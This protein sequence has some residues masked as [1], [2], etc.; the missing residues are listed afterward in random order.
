VAGG[1]IFNPARMIHREVTA[2][3]DPAE[4]F[5]VRVGAG[6]QTINVNGPEPG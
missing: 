2:P 1:F 6:P 4:F 5:V 3:G